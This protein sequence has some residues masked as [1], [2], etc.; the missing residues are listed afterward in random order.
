MNESGS[1]IKTSIQR[2]SEEDVHEKEAQESPAREVP[3]NDGEAEA[4]E[5]SETDVENILSEIFDEDE[6]NSLMISLVKG[7]SK[8]VDKYKSMIKEHTD[9][10]TASKVMKKII[11]IVKGIC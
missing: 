1:E 9:S 4:V 11:D 7:Q 10:E 2:T 3:E 5:L 6:L 8:K